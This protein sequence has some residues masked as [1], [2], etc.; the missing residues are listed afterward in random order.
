MGSSRLSNGAACLAP[1]SRPLPSVTVSD[2]VCRSIAAFVRS[3]TIPEDRE[4]SKLEGFTGP[5]VSNFYLLLVALCH[6]TSPRGKLPLE[7]TVGNRHLRGWDYLSAKLEAIAHISPIILSPSYWARIAETDLREIFRDEILGERLSDPTGRVG[8]IQDLG[9]KML[10][11]SWASAD[12]FYALSEGR[13]ASGN[14]NLLDLLSQFKAYSDPVRKKSF[15]F[16]ALMRNAGIWTYVDS[17]RLGAPVDYHEVRGHLRIGTVQI[18]D[19]DLRSKLLAGLEVTAEDD[20]SIRQAVHEA[21]MLVSEYSGLRNPSQIHYMFWNIFRSCCTRE[22]PHCYSCT[23]TC[24]LPAR[25]VPLALFPD[26]TRHCPFA[27][28]CESAGQEPKLFEHTF[29]TDYY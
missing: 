7:G 11:H 22:N 17:E 10:R 14:P 4:D 19:P 24:S 28:I 13:I 9:E 21:L 2:D 1:G 25:Y 12:G 5:Q 20:I 18:C 15:F 27:N 3:R 29:E 6:Q 8:L 16:L 26:G 23:P